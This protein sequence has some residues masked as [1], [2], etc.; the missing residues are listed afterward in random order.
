M[1]MSADARATVPTSTGT[2]PNYGVR[3]CAVAALLLTALSIGS[4]AQQPV[5]DPNVNVVRGTKLPKGDPWLQRQNE[6]SLAVSTRNPCTLLLGSNDYRPVSIAIDAFEPN[7][8]PFAAGDA[9]LGL[10]K[11]FDCGSKWESTLL[12]GFPGD[13]RPDAAQSPLHGFAAGAD[14]TVRAGT[15][16]LFYYSGIVFNRGENAESRLF[17]ARFVD[18]NNQEKGDPIADLGI[19]VVADG[20]IGQFVD[21][22]WMAVDIPRSGYGPE[23]AYWT[24]TEEHLNPGNGTAAEKG[25]CTVDGKQVPAGNVYLAWARFEGNSL[26]Y[27]SKIMFA[28]STDCGKTFQAR[29]ISDNTKISQGSMI[30]ISPDDG[31]VYVGWREF[32]RDGRPHSIHLVRSRDG[33]KS[34]DRPTPVVASFSPFDQAKTS[35]TFRTNALPTIAAAP[36]GHVYVAF[37]A[38]G[39]GKLQAA[40]GTLADN[41]DSRVVLAVSTNGGVSFNAPYPIDDNRE[42]RGHQIMPA[43]AYAAD[44]I[45]VT[46]YDFRDDAS[47]HRGSFI[48]DNPALAGNTIRHTVDVRAVWATPGARPEFVPQYGSSTVLS[49]YAFSASLGT[50]QHNYVNL[51]LYAKGT[52]PFIGDYADVAALSAFPVRNADGTQGWRPN[53]G[54]VD[55]S[56]VSSFSQSVL[57][58]LPTFH[59]AWTDHRD[60]KHTKNIHDYK[61][62]EAFVACDPEKAG[63]RNANIYTARITQGLFVGSPGNTKPLGLRVNRDGSLYRDPVTGQTELMQRS[64]AV[65]A[66]NTLKLAKRYRLTIVN[67][68]AGGVASFRQFDKPSPDCV[69]GANTVCAPVPLLSVDAVVTPLSTISRTVYAKSTDKTAQV[70]VNIQELEQTPTGQTNSDGTAVMAWTIKPNGLAGSVLL[71][72]DNTNPEII[73]PDVA[74]DIPQIA[75]VETHQPS[76]GKPIYLDATGL[77]STSRNLILPPVP[78]PENPDPENPDPENPDPENPDPEN[79]DPENPDPENPDPENPDPENPDP[80]NPD[81]EN[82]SI[83]NTGVG[84]NEIITAMRDV[85]WKVKNRG[86]TRSAFFFTPV[87]KGDISGLRFQ[88]IVTRQY[89]TPKL[90]PLTCSVVYKNESQ[91]V[92]NVPNYTPRTPDPENPDPENPDPENPD[93]E[94]PDPENPDPENPD[95]ENPDPEN[96]DPENVTF[97]LAPGET[98]TVTLRVFTTAAATSTGDDLA[99]HGPSM[100]APPAAIINFTPRQQTA[101]F[102]SAQ[103]IATNRTEEQG[104]ES[105]A[106]G[107]DLIVSDPAPS[108]DAAGITAD[109]T[110]TVS[111]TIKNQGD[112]P[113]EIPGLNPGPIKTR[114][115]LSTDDTLDPLDMPLAPPGYSDSPATFFHA[116]QGPIP[117]CIGVGTDVC[118]RQGTQQLRI[119]AN[120]PVSPQYFLFVIVDDDN[121]ADDAESTQVDNEVFEANDQN[122]R[123]AARAPVGPFTLVFEGTVNDTAAGSLLT[124]RAGVFDGPVRVSVRDAYNQL[125]PPSFVPSA[126]IAIGTNP[127]A[128]TLTGTLT[129][130]NVGGFVTF[131]D[132]RINN[133]GTGY[134]LRS[135]STAQNVLDG[136]SNAFLIDDVPVANGDNYNATEE[137]TLTVAAPGVLANDTNLQGGALKAILVSG[138][139]TGTLN[140]TTSGGFTYTPPSNFFGSVTFTYRATD[141]RSESGIATVTITVANAPDAP[142]ANPDSA[143]TFTGRSVDIPV[144]ANDTDVDGDTLAIQSVTTPSNGTAVI[145]D[146][147]IS[148]TPNAGFSGSDSFSYTA[149]DPGGLTATALVSVIVSAASAA[150]VANPDQATTFENTPVTINVLGNDRDPDGFVQGA[151]QFEA[152]GLRANIPFINEIVVNPASGLVYFGGGGGPKIGVVEPGTNRLAATVPIAATLGNVNLGVANPATGFLYF[153]H[154]FQTTHSIVAVD[155]RPTSAAFNTSINVAL[156]ANKRIQAFAVDSLRGLLYVSTFTPQPSPPSLADVTILD[157]NPTSATF[158]QIVGTVALP[159]GTQARGIAVNRETNKIYVAVGGN[160]ANAGLWIVDGTS[161]TAVRV[162]NTNNGFS[163]AVNQ[164]SNLVYMTASTG[165]GG[166]TQYQIQAIDGPTATLLATIPVANVLATGNYSERIAIHEGSGQVYV[167]TTDEGPSAR[168][169]AVDGRRTSATFNTIVANIPVPFDGGNGEIAVAEAANRLVAVSGGALANA[170]TVI[171]TTTNQIVASYATNGSSEVSINQASN[172]AYVTEGIGAIRSLNLLTGAAATIPTGVETGPMVVNPFNGMAFGGHTGSAIASIDFVTSDGSFGN[173]TNGMP[174]QLGRYVFFGIDA[175]QQRVYAANAS[176]DIAGARADG[177]G[178]LSIINAANQSVIANVAAGAGPFGVAV[179]ETANK[180]YVSNL[181][182]TNIQGG[183]TI[184]SGAAPYPTTQADVSAFGDDVGFGRDIV[185]SMTGKVYARATSGEFGFTAGVLDPGTNVVTPL[186]TALGVVRLIR[187]DPTRNR[188]YLGTTTGTGDTEAHNVVVLNSADQSVVATIPVGFPSNFV[189]AGYYLAVDAS[190]NRLFVANFRNDSVSVLDRDTFAVLATIPVGD[191]PTAV[192]VNEATNRIYVTNPGDKT[193]SIIDGAT[194]TEVSRRTLPLRAISL[195]IDPQ[196]HRLFTGGSVFDDGGVLVLSDEPAHRGSSLIVTA[197]NPAHGTVQVN[198]DQTVTYTPALNYFGPDSF[199]YAINDGRGGFDTAQVTVSVLHPNQPPLANDD[200]F[201]TNEDTARAGNVLENDTDDG[202]TLLTA[203]V[204][205]QPKFGSLVFSPSGNFTYTPQANFHGTDTF[206]YQMTDGSGGSSRATV[207]LIVNS[208]ED[209]VQGVGTW[210]ASAHIGN[211]NAEGAPDAIASGPLFSTDRHLYVKEGLGGANVVLSEFGPLGS[212]NHSRTFSVGNSPRSGIAFDPITEDVLATDINGSTSDIVALGLIGGP[213]ITNVVDLPWKVDHLGNGTGQQQFAVHPSGNLLYFWDNTQATLYK[214]DRNGTDMPTPLR[215]FDTSTPVGQHVATRFNDVAFEERVGRVLV[216]DGSTNAVVDAAPGLPAPIAVFGGL[217]GTPGALAVDDNR[218]KAY[219]QIGDSIFGGSTDDGTLQLVATVP[220]LIDFT[221]APSPGGGGRSLFALTA[222]SV[223]EVR[224]S[225]EPPTARDDVITVNEDTVLNLAVMAN[226]SDASGGPLTIIAFSQPATGTGSVTYGS[227]RRTLKYTPPPNF[228]GTATFTYTIANF[229]AAATATVTINFA[230]VNDPPVANFDSY[231]TPQDQTL[232]VAAP[233]VLANDTDVDGPGPMTAVLATQ[234]TT[235]TLTFNS[236]GSFTYVP[237]P[238]FTGGVKFSYRAVDGAGAQSFT[239]GVVINVRAPLAITTTVIHEA[240]LFDFYNAGVNSTGGRT[241]ITFGLDASSAPL[242]SGVNVVSFGGSSGGING[243][244]ANTGIFDITVRATD[245]STPVKQTDTQPLTLRSSARDQWVFGGPANAGVT[246]GATAGRELAQ[247]ITTGLQGL[248]SAVRIDNTTCD[249]GVR[250]AVDVQGVTGEFPAKPNGVVLATGTGTPGF[251]PVQLT[252][253]YFLPVES[254]VAVVVRAV[255]GNCQM[256]N[257]EPRGDF[258]PLGTAFS[259]GV[260]GETVGQWEKLATSHGFADIAVQNNVI[261]D[262]V[263]YTLKWRDEGVVVPLDE[264]RVLIMGGWWEPQA[265]VY[266]RRT[267]QFTPTANTM[268]QWRVNF[269]A[270]LLPDGRVLIVGGRSAATFSD[271]V[272]PVDTAEV[273]DPITN[274]FTAVTGRLAV[275]RSQHTATPLADG[276]VLIYGGLRLN[277]TMWEGTGTVEVW[278]GTGFSILGP[279]RPLGRYGHTATR[280]LPAAGNRVLIVGGWWTGAGPPQVELFDPATNT[281]SIDVAQLPNR[282]EHTAT[283]LND[284]RVLVAGGGTSFP[285]LDPYRLYNPATNTWEDG[286]PMAFPRI[287]HR[288]TPLGDGSVLITGG[289]TNWDN[290]VPTALMERFVPA[291]MGGAGGSAVSAGM[292]KVTRGRHAAAAMA[293]G[294]VF[295]AGGWS[296]SNITRRAA[297]SI[298]PAALSFVIKTS[299]LPDGFVGSV[300]P[301]TALETAGGTPPITFSVA[302]GSPPQGLTLNAN[303]TITGTPQAA[304]PSSFV[305]RAQDSAGNV[306]LQRLTIYVNRLVITTTTLPAGVRGAPYNAQLE[307]TGFGAKTWS[308]VPFS[309]TPPTGLTLN[310]DGSITGTIDPNYTCCSSF[311]AQVVDAAGQTAKKWFFIPVNDPLTIQT[312]SADL[313]DATAPWNYFGGIWATGGVAPHTFDVIEGALPTGVT[314]NENGSFSGNVLKTGIFNFVARVR[315][316]SNPQLSATRS[317]TIRAATSDQNHGFVADPLAWQDFGGNVKIA[318]VTRSGLDGVLFNISA[319]VECTAAALLLEAF[320]VKANGEPDFD[321]PPLGSST[322]P[323]NYVSPFAAGSYWMRSLRFDVPVAM[324]YESPVAIVMSSTGSCRIALPKPTDPDH[325]HGGAFVISNPVETLLSKKGV[326]DFPFWTGIHPNGE[327]AWAEHGRSGH[328]ATVLQNGKVLIA[329]GTSFGATA[330]VYDPATGLMTPTTSAM[331]QA[332]ANHTA[333][334]L[335]DGRVL[336]VGGHSPNNWGAPAYA[337]GEIFDPAT[338]AFSGVGDMKTVDNIPQPRTW[339]TATRFL[340]GD[341]L[342]TGGTA[343][344]GQPAL[345]STHVFDV[346]TNMFT[347]GPNMSRAR[348]QHQATLL[349]AGTNQGGSVLITGGWGGQGQ[350]PIAEKLVAGGGF[351][352]LTFDMQRER[353]EHSAV[354][355]DCGR[356][357]QCVLV[358]GGWDGTNGGFALATELFDIGGDIFFAGGSLRQGRSNP[359]SAASTDGSAVIMG[360]STFGP[361]W[362]TAA[363]ERYDPATINFTVLRP[364]GTD[365]A[366]HTASPI[367]GNRVLVAFGSGMSQAAWHSA[368]VY[369]LN[370]AAPALTI[371]TIRVND[372]VVDQPYD[373][374]IQSTSPVATYSIVRGA[375]PPGLTLQPNGRLGGTPTL[376]G[377]FRFVVQA[378]DGVNVTTRGFFMDV[379]TPLSITTPSL[380]NGTVGTPYNATV[381]AQGGISWHNWRIY[382]GFFP[383]GLSLFGDGRING[384]PTTP[385][386]YNFR[387]EVSDSATP[388]QSVIRAFT[389]IVAPAWTFT[390]DMNVPRSG[391]TA[392][393]LNNGRVLVVNGNDGGS[394]FDPDQGRQT[395]FTDTVELYDSNTGTWSFTGSTRVI[396]GT[397][398]AVRLQDGRVLIAGG[399]KE[400]GVAQTAAEIY[401]PATGTWTLTG[402]MNQ[403]RVLHTLTLLPSGKVLA[404]GGWGSG[405]FLSSAELYDPVSGAWSGTGA[406]A[407][408]RWQQTA[409]LLNDGT[410]LVAGGENYGFCP[411]CSLTAAEIYN[412]ATGTWSPT[413]SL[414]NARATHRAELL[415]NGRVLVAGGLVGAGTN[416]LSSAELYDP[417]TGQWS[418]TGVLLGSR[419]SFVSARL[420]DGTV[421]VAGGR[422]IPGG[423]ALDGAERYDATTGAWTAEPTLKQARYNHAAVLLPDGRVLVIGGYDGTNILKNAEILVPGR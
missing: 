113:A 140:L 162:P 406:M 358:A 197:Q 3:G 73:Q 119:P 398:T 173:V 161:R 351:M 297:E 383:P 7:V 253:P 76:I 317:L 273:F 268:S 10:F 92:V 169:L 259:R 129:R 339:H 252:T 369:D 105:A 269:T 1:D 115:Y 330:L 261:P 340:N 198:A 257:L 88:M 393:L 241:P 323:A 412:P 344:G 126:T 199:T 64:F 147:V 229:H 300:Y 401:D 80:E 65:F 353:W 394:R 53:A 112:A 391:H 224:S 15:N 322:V 172:T 282:F 410:V 201:A 211:L 329:G 200:L 349:P 413:G 176:S 212:R 17:V 408:G 385:G 18:R 195:A 83:L 226:D 275:G 104:P 122:N 219:V 407:V 299:T 402:P 66:Q 260:A 286:G 70:L 284:G 313:Q 409:T 180:I 288:A 258:Y 363:V 254:P 5:A 193:L 121:D 185:V 281:F 325:P 411:E 164:A 183:I 359:R 415:L 237:D 152:A 367:A 33:G 196:R 194:L 23:A 203:S 295:V 187:A 400:N 117:A 51:P 332:R 98:A 138:P 255:G 256:S 71:N 335:A 79:P 336:I 45:K 289:S 93:P 190:Q 20:R 21:K 328:T 174:H 271:P 159:N 366:W 101:A 58:T 4:A 26:K 350:G 283:L 396:H 94:N 69:P 134:T 272:N 74:G 149:R 95:P 240:T 40:D 382:D 265:E 170:V 19:T 100:S 99:G 160:L 355:V 365:R 210:Q 177:E 27:P 72:P 312:T 403:G 230:A 214:V 56:G 77:L 362:Q 87:I 163:V 356:V 166:S 124:S 218:G 151:S 204:V 97:M 381:Q 395:A 54:S 310:A 181:G 301:A 371:T 352:P 47:P 133:G 168:V 360:G 154:V 239:Q 139:A 179:D 39:Y 12:K 231:D 287:D 96:P 114:F 143:E 280:L 220:G 146:N 245:S 319:P 364:L 347:P 62:P 236:D 307:A 131:D 35:Y 43:I 293:D 292:L 30:A 418:S 320:D 103:A 234:P 16:G 303:G 165:S 22:P 324:P 153:R 243:S 389:I 46:Y 306:A 375:A 9:W 78:D 316:S 278:D 361:H 417:T 404:A 60:V 376:A 31:T 314:L 302:S 24:A 111:F 61:L 338:G 238:G 155:G 386:T 84:E 108:Y 118:L 106:V 321:K 390:G 421:L 38:R 216:S 294:S 276:R 191:G 184:V 264:N 86:N 305:A 215:S 110:I 48:S 263:K 82:Q 8:D 242:P 25:M 136:V 207:T 235:G 75:T 42:K 405:A 50:V 304:G 109:S 251:I 309:G 127:S 157:I 379:G 266:D 228:A 388:R 55:M 37:A 142:V 32:G 291:G 333:T 233:G 416:T 102:I 125:V 132:L 384:T 370:T 202:G 120:I 141:G 57:P 368:E 36:G 52:M 374:V 331:I 81:P 178:F 89:L 357:Y 49:Q 90:N 315:D 205:R 250:L 158:H 175:T 67:Q 123:A 422:R 378:T 145:V 420:L 85:H 14:P 248:L 223:Y 342:I 167:K 188:V 186:P 135:A 34:W 11:S 192:A 213:R 41:D 334:L 128:G 144:L 63:L 208:V 206:V 285:E 148:Y 91:V 277:G 387:V 225:G 377:S 337:S 262:G 221:T 13:P 107:P 274:Q 28:R 267:G 270:T 150:P 414:N 298:E 227:D 392:T 423:A 6:P 341:V 247:V 156:P 327:Y 189:G 346:G 130:A 348:A 380:P 217:S 311:Q 397:A 354:L 290:R 249:A 244:P 343:G 29:P 171:D 44:K 326:H 372:G 345:I 232:V 222:Q 209:G 68:P 373:F 182:G 279:D 246:F 296:Y 137:Q 2:S 116:T 308:L 399:R 318:Q 59:A 419:D